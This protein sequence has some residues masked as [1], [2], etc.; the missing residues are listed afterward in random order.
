MSAPMGA[1][2]KPKNK[3]SVLED[4]SAIAKGDVAVAASWNASAAETPGPSTVKRDPETLNREEMLSLARKYATD[5]A[6]ALVDGE[7]QREDA[8]R[9]KDSIKLSCIQDRLSNMKLSKRLADEHLRATAR[10]V[11][12]DDELNLRHEFRGV[13]LA[14]E[15]VSQLHKELLECVGESLEVTYNGGTDSTRASTA[16]ASDPGGTGVETPLSIGR[17]RR[18]R[19]SRLSSG[20]GSGGRAGGQVELGAA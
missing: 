9:T 1:T 17:R 19:I 13:E 6:E 2:A 8:V 4:R 11:I 12:R 14:H 7:R 5:I 16:G 18:A 15:R 10:P 3:T 20:S